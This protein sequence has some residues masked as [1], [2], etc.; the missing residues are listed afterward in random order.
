MV[1]DGGKLVEIASITTHPD[2]RKRDPGDYDVAIWKLKEPVKK[3]DGIAFAKL[4][5]A[6][7]FPET[8]LMA[9][10]AGW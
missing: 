9:G 1:N 10:V 4:A 8:G 2:H 6:G 3:G 7:K 5:D